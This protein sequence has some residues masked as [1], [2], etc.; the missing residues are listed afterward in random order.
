M[1][2]QRLIDA[3]KEADTNGSNMD[4]DQIAWLIGSFPGHTGE[5]LKSLCEDCPRIKKLLPEMT[6]ERSDTLALLRVSNYMNDEDTVGNIADLIRRV[7][8]S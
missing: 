7:V 8:R 5:R 2:D 1:S 4:V 6:A 3:L